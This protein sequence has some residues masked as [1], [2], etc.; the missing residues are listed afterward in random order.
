MMFTVTLNAVE[1]DAEERRQ[2]AIRARGVMEGAGWLFDE[3]ISELTREMLDTDASQTDRRERIF[4][5]I[6]AV[7]RLKGALIQILRDEE[8][9]KV[10]NERKHRADPAA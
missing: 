6:L 8:A 2:R 4:T 10:Q 3:Q 7:S 1:L 5:E 9:R